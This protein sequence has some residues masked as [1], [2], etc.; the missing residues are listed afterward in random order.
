MPT[1][2]SAGSRAGPG[3]RYISKAGYSRH[4]LVAF[5]KP[6]SALT[7]PI[8]PKNKQPELAKTH[9]L[10]PF[11]RGYHSRVAVHT[12]DAR[13]GV[14]E[15]RS[16]D[17]NSGEPRSRALEDQG[18]QG[19]GRLPREAFWFRLV[20]GGDAGLKALKPETAFPPRS[21][22]I[23]G[24]LGPSGRENDKRG[25]RRMALSD[26]S[27]ER[28]PGSVAERPGSGSGSAGHRLF[29]TIELT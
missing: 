27:A 22:R 9:R 1:R 20:T 24:E 16:H 26:T 14:K 4:G 10:A 23:R 17:A 28:W 3:N 19:R 6:K 29:C 2:S 13:P 21:A 18:R 8:P 5:S 7:K 15:P 12:S 11:R 25:Q